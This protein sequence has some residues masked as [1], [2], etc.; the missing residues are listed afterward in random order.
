MI[1][2]TLD[3]LT[4]YNILH[5]MI[6]YTLDILTVYNILHYM[7]IKSHLSFEYSVPN[8]H[9]ILLNGRLGEVG[10]PQQ[11]PGKVF[12]RYSGESSGVLLELHVQNFLLQVLCEPENMIY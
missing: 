12:L 1:I 11:Y 4:V 7:I 9:Q 10:V 5:Y 8:S 2:Y 6:I 3:I